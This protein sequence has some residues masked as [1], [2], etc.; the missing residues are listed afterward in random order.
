[1]APYEVLKSYAVT[2][3]DYNEKKNWTHS[4][5]ALYTQDFYED[6]TVL[7]AVEVIRS[8]FHDLG[9]FVVVTSDGIVDPQGLVRVSVRFV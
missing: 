7:D 8:I 3:M 4:S 6:E 2:L 9:A 1:M 5:I